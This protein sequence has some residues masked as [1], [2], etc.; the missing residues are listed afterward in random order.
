MWLPLKKSCIEILAFPSTF[1]LASLSSKTNPA[2][3]DMAV[4]PAVYIRKNVISGN[5]LDMKQIQTDLSKFFQLD[6]LIRQEIF[7]F[8]PWYE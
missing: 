7:P 2:S 1:F 3:F 6:C 8:I 4:P 5:Y